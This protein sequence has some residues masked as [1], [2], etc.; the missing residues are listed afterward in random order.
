MKR[1][2]IHYIN[3]IST[4]W[5]NV[6]PVHQCTP[7]MDRPWLR[8]STCLSGPAAFSYTRAAVSHACP[9]EPPSNK[10]SLWKEKCEVRNGHWSEKSQ[11][12]RNH[13]TFLIKVRARTDTQADSAFS[14]S[15]RPRP[16]GIAAHWCFRSKAQAVCKTGSTKMSALLSLSM[17][18]TSYRHRETVTRVTKCKYWK[19]YSVAKKCIKHS[20]WLSKVLTSHKGI[21]DKKKKMHEWRRDEDTWRRAS[22]RANIIRWSLIV[23]TARTNKHLFI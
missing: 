9:G 13:M 8:S 19:H 1:R 21:S 3:I 14:H 17:F 5:N 12:Y 2:V 22:G 20:L 6:K 10:T 11:H 4:S 18:K 7:H 23:D 16:G 15:R